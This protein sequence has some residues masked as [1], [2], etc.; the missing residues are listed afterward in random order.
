MRIS[1]WSSD[2]CSSDLRSRAPAPGARPRGKN[3]E[4]ARQGL[5]QGQA[6]AKPPGLPPRLQAPARGGGAPGGCAAK[7]GSEEGRP[8][9]DRRRKARHPEA[10]HHKASQSGQR[11]PEPC[12]SSP[13]VIE[14][15]ASRHPTPSPFARPPTARKTTRLNSS[16]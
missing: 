3:E 8:R 2:V 13:A 4:E 1:D 5:R 11:P 16:H 6:Q 15:A 10:P 14:A 12:E 9:A 7:A